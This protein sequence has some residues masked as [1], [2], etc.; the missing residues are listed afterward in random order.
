LKDS[1]IGATTASSHQMLALTMRSFYFKRPTG[2]GGGQNDAAARPVYDARDISIEVRGGRQ[3][4][5]LTIN[6]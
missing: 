5:L 2:C 6:Y 3:W 4:P 1:T